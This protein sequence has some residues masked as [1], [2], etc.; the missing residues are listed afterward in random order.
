MSAAKAFLPH[1]ALM[2]DLWGPTLLAEDI[3]RLQDPSVGGVILFRRNYKTRPQLVDL[4]RRIR[5]LRVPELL[6]AVDQEGGRVQQF[7]EGF[8]RLPP[9]AVFGQL[10]DQADENEEEVLSLAHSTAQ[11]MAQELIEIGVD[12]SFAPVLDLGLFQ[13]TIIGDRAFHPAPEKLLTIARA[14]I[15]GMKAAGM[16]AT[17]KH[18][19]GHGSVL[20]DSHLE[21]PIDARE[22]EKLKANDLLPYVL[23]KHEIAAIMT[24]HI[25]YPAIDESLPAYSSYWLQGVLREEIGFSGLIFSDDL[26]MGGACTGESL[27]WRIERAISAGCDMVLI[28]NDHAAIDKMLVQREFVASIESQQRIKSMKARPSP[29]LNLVRSE[30]EELEARFSTLNTK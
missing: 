27:T 26:S 30:I 23:L 19:P 12:I 7:K 15:Q 8:T 18:F 22:Y 4:I 2:V 13:K 9:M 28:L 21:T 17:A 24:A 6:V 14:F 1:G 3:R 5:D 20:A 25:D 10:L 11:L 16:S 29:N